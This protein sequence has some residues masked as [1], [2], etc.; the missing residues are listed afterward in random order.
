MKKGLITIASLLFCMHLWGSPILDSLSYF[1]KK[2]DLKKAIRL[3]DKVDVNELHSDELFKF[4]HTSIEVYTHAKEFENAA[5]FY[6]L[7]SEMKRLNVRQ[8]AL[9]DLARANLF[10]EMGQ[11]ND[12]A[13][14][15]SRI[16]KYKP[17]I[18]DSSFLVK[19]NALKVIY[20]NLS[21]RYRE[22]ME[23]ATELLKYMSRKEDPERKASL[24]LTIGEI[25]R[26]NSLSDKA[27]FYYQKAE[28]IAR[29]HKF[30]GLLGKAYNN[31]SIIHSDRNEQD[32]SMQK[33]K[34]SA[35]LY[36]L[37][38]GELSA[39]PVYHNLGLRYLDKNDT[40]NALKYFR[41]VLEI[42]QDQN[43]S[44]AEF[45]GYL[46]IG[47]YYKSLRKYEDADYYFQKALTLAK[48][49]KVPADIGRTYEQLHLLFEEAGEFQESLKYFKLS[50]DL[51]D[52]LNMA[53]NKMIID[54]LE[55]KY[56]LSESERENK[57]LRLKQTRQRLS[58]F[59]AGGIILVLLLV[60]ILFYMGIRS[61][62][63][64]NRLLSIQKDQIDAK[65]KQLKKLN[66][67]VNAQ[68][69]QLEALNNTKDAMFSIISHDLRSPLGSVYMLMNMLES[70]GYLEGKSASMLSDLTHEVH[71][72]LFLLNNLMTWAHLNIHDLKANAEIISLK[73]SIKD[74]L[75]HFKSDL[76][77][78]NISVNFHFDANYKLLEDRYIV[79][80][81]LK[82]VIS[83]AI[84]FSNENE[85]VQ[86]KADRDNHKI[87]VYVINYGIE[88]P[89][90]K[91]KQIFEPGVRLQKGT[92][93]ERGAGLGLAICKTYMKLIDADFGIKSDNG[94]TTVSM[95]FNSEPV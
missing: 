80:T 92:K 53:E 41:K 73:E 51:R 39:A 30:W 69:S 43:F 60:M 9:L 61:K 88:I 71:H 2:N 66:E 42:G 35:R 27:Y 22:A 5:R 13:S 65:N 63:K 64:Q 77:R 86:I 76:D 25:F 90:L 4:Y 17:E 52:S 94:L 67:E 46:G 36:K 85:S 1:N 93:D 28:E 38:Y 95:T 82:N 23:Y 12:V 54:G 79:E 84:K 6:D 18:S 48:K 78:K 31:Q 56:R 74:I 33:L 91:S 37:A 8:K 7:A 11:L 26:N 45:F 87:K 81:I 47:M 83:N 58:F 32:L 62:N 40:D 10:L 49:S 21:G 70:E 55:A 89:Y 72:A 3:I 34:E 50:N 44:K 57:T 20:Y 14:C 16:D 29:E 19:Y 15:F 75:I 68:K 24:Y 59:I